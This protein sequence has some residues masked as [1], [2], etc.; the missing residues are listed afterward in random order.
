M[1]QR[2]YPRRKKADG[3]FSL[4]ELVTAVFIIA[5]GVTALIG[6]LEAS[7]KVTAVNRETNKAS[8]HLQAVMEK[9]ISVPF[10]DIVRTYPNGT[11]AYLQSTGLSDL[12]E[13]EHIVVEYVDEDADPLQITLTV[14]WTS[15]D[16]RQ[17]SRSLTTLRTR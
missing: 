17:R 1:T 16:G 12:M 11:V 14:H 3:G 8:A 5:V 9:V 4:V 10:S 7:Y 6:Q 2:H 13:G 15:F